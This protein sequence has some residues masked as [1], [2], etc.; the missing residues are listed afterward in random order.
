MRTGKMSKGKEANL[1][2]RQKT[3]TIPFG[4]F[5]LYRL[6]EL[7]NLCINADISNMLVST[8]HRASDYLNFENERENVYHNTA[9]IINSS[10]VLNGAGL[11][12]YPK[13]ASYPP[14]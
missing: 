1:N 14:F 7:L 4:N 12:P 11:V 13:P 8:L 3:I 5:N 2:S 10:R 9:L 6:I